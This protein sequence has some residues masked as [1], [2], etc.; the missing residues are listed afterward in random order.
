MEYIVKYNGDVLSLGYPTELLG[1]QYAILELEPDEVSEL[2][3]YPQIEYFELSEGLS[4]FLQAG[5]DSACITPIKRDEAFGLTGTGVMIG[6]I[7][8]GIDLTH[9]EFLTE[10]GATRVLW[11]WD[12]TI[13]GSPPLGF[14]KGTVYSAREIDEGNT[15][16]RD[17]VGHGTAAAAIAAG[18]SGIAPGAAIVAVKMG[19]GN[20]A[21]STDVMRGIK[22]IMDCAAQ[23]AM[24]CVINLSYGT[25]KGS[26]QG[27]SL[28]ETYIDTMAQQ[29]RTVIVCASGNEGDSGHHFSG[30]LSSGSILDVEFTVSTPRSSIFLT[31][32]KSFADIARFEMILPSGASTGPLSSGA[33]RQFSFGPVQLSA[34]FNGPTHFS[35]AQEVYYTLSAPSGQLNGL[36]KLRCYGDRIVEG[37]F[38]IW[39][40]T[41]EEVGR[42]TAFL[43]PDP[44]LT[45]TLPATARLPISVGGYR[46]GTGTASTFSGRGA[47]PCQGHALL[48]LCAPAEQIYTA[49]AGGGY[50]TYSGTSMA[51]PFVSGSAALLMEWGIIQRNDPFLYGQRIK[52]FLCANAARSTFLNYPDPVWGYGKLNLCAA[53]ADLVRQ[54]ERGTL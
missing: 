49:K 6:F 32:W 9:P 16:S 23:E 7:D 21:T 18:R 30:K 39:L 19:S 33:A 8:S 25:N 43:L 10:N 14:R 44:N 47:A 42:D 26:H 35:T 31:L 13:P 37:G 41:V 53:L 38:N 29:G 1:H 34:V 51:A 27:Q 11:L 46:S 24:P 22:F 15:D 52:A 2:L 54:R 50:D 3:E 28:F 40:P 4:P 36:W 17:V 45:I 20:S 48:D 12:M 5:L